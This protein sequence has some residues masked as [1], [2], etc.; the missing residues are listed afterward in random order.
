[1]D[2]YLGIVLPFAGNFAPEGWLLCQG[3]TLPISQYQALFT[4]LGTVYGGNGTTNF[5]L[6]NL[7]GRVVVSAGRSAAGTSYNLG[8]SAGVE[9]EAVSANNLPSHTHSVAAVPHT[10]T[11]N[12][13]AHT[14]PLALQCDNN[15]GGDQTPAG[16]YIGNGGAYS[17]SHAQTMAAQVTGSDNGTLA[18]GTTATATSPAGTTGPT[19]N[20]APLNVMQPYQVLNYI[21]CVQGIFPV[22]P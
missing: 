13:P 7:Q 1:M 11:F 20:N 5:Q 18:G 16:E 14:H 8:Y 12:L 6:P 22:R 2:A 17:T 21:I 9:Q 19:G 15:N 3:Q 4:I 10:H